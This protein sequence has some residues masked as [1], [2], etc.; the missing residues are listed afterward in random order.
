MNAFWS[1]SVKTKRDG[2]TERPTDGQ[3]DG[4]MDGRMDRQTGGGG[5][6]CNI[7]RPGLSGDNK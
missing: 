3:T 5:G 2:R 1:Y 6:C 7:S 4:Q